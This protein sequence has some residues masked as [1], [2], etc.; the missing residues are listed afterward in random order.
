LIADLDAA[1]FATRQAARTTLVKLGRH[2]V[3]A[4]AEAELA[5]PSLTPT[6][7]AGLE[8][9]LTDLTVEE[10]GS[11]AIRGLRAVE[12]LER[13]GTTD[14]LDQLAALAKGSS[15]SRLTREAK[16]ALQRLGKASR[17]R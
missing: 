9:V 4:A 11:R 14:A 1:E 2:Q 12:L 6:M 10:S 5:K 16:E 15:E 3:G 13:L 7:R 8:G 17:G